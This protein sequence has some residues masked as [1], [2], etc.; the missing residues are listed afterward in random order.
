MA[1]AKNYVLDIAKE[2]FNRMDKPFL[3]QCAFKNVD[4]DKIDFENDGLNVTYRGT[5]DDFLAVRAFNGDD[6]IRKE[7]ANS[8]CLGPLEVNFCCL[9]FDLKAADFK[10]YKEGSFRAYPEFKNCP[11]GLEDVYARWEIS[12]RMS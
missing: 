4:M 9:I 7:I 8:K 3:S 10:F 5:L 1:T 11:Q 2:K 12:Q 6:R